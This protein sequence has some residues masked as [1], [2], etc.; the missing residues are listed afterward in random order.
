M[1]IGPLSLL[2][3]VTLLHCVTDALDTIQWFMGQHVN[4]QLD[5]ERVR[6]TGDLTYVTFQLEMVRYVY[7]GILGMYEKY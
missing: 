1:S 2:L 5:R 4:C 7:G 6:V 3:I